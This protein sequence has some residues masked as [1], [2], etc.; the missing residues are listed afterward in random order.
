MAASP[1]FK[2]YDESGEYQGCVKDLVLAA[3][4]VSTLGAGATIRDGHR[5][6]IWREGHED[7]WAGNS[8]DVCADVCAERIGGDFP[9]ARDNGPAPYGTDY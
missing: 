6:V 9:P 7:D 3:A 4:L 1:R 5:T 8:Y 2:V